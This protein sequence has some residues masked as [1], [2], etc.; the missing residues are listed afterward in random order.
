MTLLQ[1]SAMETTF[2]LKDVIYIAAFLVSIL[3]AW[4]KLQADKQKMQ[5]QIDM[6]I[7]KLSKHATDNKVQMEKMEMLHKEENLGLKNTLRNTKKEMDTTIDK[8]EQVTHQRI[9]RVRDDNIKTYE[10][11]EKRIDDLDKKGDEHTKVI[12]EAI[13]KS[14]S[15]K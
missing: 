15:S 2:T 4:F 10:K 13:S 5:T 3:T 14:K 6:L 11:L 1:T 12:L 7:E 8:K 9:D